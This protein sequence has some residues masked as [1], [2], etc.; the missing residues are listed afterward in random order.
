MKCKLFTGIPILN[1]LLSQRGHS[2]IEEIS[3]HMH[4][5][6]CTCMQVSVARSASEQP[7][8]KSYSG[9]DGRAESWNAN[10]GFVVVTVPGVASVSSGSLE[11]V[12]C[13]WLRKRV[14]NTHAVSWSPV[15][16]CSIC[17]DLW[18]F[19][20]DLRDLR[21]AFQ[22]G[23]ASMWIHAQKLLPFFFFFF[24]QSY[25][26]SS[27]IVI[28]WLLLMGPDIWSSVTQFL[29]KPPRFSNMFQLPD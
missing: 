16:G 1:F 11:A 6:S 29:L 19:W 18:H 7:L 13:L 8:K 17:C 3:P 2:S 21:N 24:P 9:W 23:V 25:F 20:K 22:I 27:W 26:L 14:V 12:K 4:V 5:T 15:S 10:L 28:C